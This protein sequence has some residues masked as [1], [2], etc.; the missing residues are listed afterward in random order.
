MLKQHESLLT[1]KKNLFNCAQMC[2]A[3][4]HRKLRNLTCTVFSLNTTQMDKI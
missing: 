3:F 2:K 1:E 4:M